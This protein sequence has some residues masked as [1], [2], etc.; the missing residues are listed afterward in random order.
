MADATP[1]TVAQ[2]R[3]RGFIT[4]LGIGQIISWG[5]LYYSFPVIAE[6]MGH[7]LGLDKTTL[8]GAATIG[9]IIASLATFPIGVAI[10][11]GYGRVVM[12][13]GS[14]LAGALLLVWSHV[15]GLW[16]FFP[17]MAGIGLA[18][19]MTLYEPAFA[20]IA[21]HQGN[22]ARNGITA[23]TLWGG[24]A[25]TVFVPLIEFL[26]VQIDWR[27]TLVVLGFLNLTVCLA[28]HAWVLPR[29]SSPRSVSK[30]ISNRSGGAHL[31]RWALGQPVF[32]GLLI[33]FTVYA[34]AFSGLSY[35]LYPLLVARS[36]DPAVV[37]AAI[38]IVGPAQVAGRLLIW[39]FAGKATV[40]QIGRYAVWMLPLALGFLVVLPH[41]M[42]A[43]AAFAIVYGAANGI[44][45]I[46]RGLAVPE[47]LSR[48]SY[49]A[50]NSLLSIPGLI[51]R[52]LAPLIVALAWES[53]GS[54]EPVLL[55]ILL[56]S[57]IVVAA[58]G[59]AAQGRPSQPLP[60]LPARAVE[61]AEAVDNAHAESEIP[62]LPR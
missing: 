15:N 35:H 51:A 58:F 49:G 16:A 1:T 39:R 10:D 36:F 4:G 17:L 30:S 2:P 22:D 57:V 32:W 18:Q 3:P 19:A 20:V 60:T 59:L 11:R 45:T 61:S 28:V 12:S 33:A 54:Y 34:T 44:L 53:W 42:A 55:V 23:L 52:S 27:S 47:M 56:G 29:R 13:S 48:D 5:T 7:D 41:H 21:R 6:R 24:F 26:I 37:V 50:L 46:V 31:T 25:S 62:D 38:A 9:L 14:A 40:R 43:L 8:F